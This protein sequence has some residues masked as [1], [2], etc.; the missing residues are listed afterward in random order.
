MKI[1]SVVFQ[2]LNSLVGTSTIH[3]PDNGVFAIVGPTG[4][5]KTTILDAICLALYGRTPRLNN[6]INSD[7]KE[8]EIISR[9][10][11]NCFAEVEFET[12]HNE[13]YIARWEHNRTNKSAKPTHRLYAYSNTNEKKILHGKTTDV[14]NNIQQITGLDFIQFTRSVLLAQGDFA[15]F[16][17]SDDKDRAEILEKITG[18]EIYKNISKKVYEKFKEKECNLKLLEEKLNEIKTLT[19]DEINSLNNNVAN[20]DNE[21]KLLSKKQ[22]SITDFLTFHKKLTEIQNESE[23]IKRNINSLNTAETEFHNDAAKLAAA[24]KANEINNQYNNYT[25]QKKLHDGIIKTIADVETDLPT[26]NNE[27]DNAKKNAE[28]SELLYNETKNNCEINQK[29]SIAAR[30]YDQKINELS[31]IIR[32]AENDK[33]ERTKKIAKLEKEQIEHE[34]NLAEILQEK[35]PELL[36]QK[37][38]NI[39]NTLAE[40]LNGKNISE[41]TDEREQLQ[42]KVKKLQFLYDSIVRI[43]SIN[44]DQNKIE[45][46]IQISNNSISQLEN[47]CIEIDEQKNLIEKYINELREKKQLLAVIAS[48]DEHRAKLENGKPC[49]LCGA[50]QHPYANGADPK[51]TNEE[52]EIKNTEEKIKNVN[53][54][55]KQ[56]NEKLAEK[57]RER[58]TWEIKRNNNIELI[59]QIIDKSNAAGVDKLPEKN[60]VQTEINQICLAADKIKKQIDETEKLN[61]EQKELNEKLQKSHKTNLEIQKIKAQIQEIKFENINTE[62]EINETGSKLN[63][64][65]EERIKIFGNENPDESDKK[66]EQLLINATK[67]R[68]ENNKI[69]AA[70]KSKVDNLTKRLEMLLDEKTKRGAEV[71]NTKRIFDECCIGSG[72]GTE[73]EFLSAIIEAE[74]LNELRAKESKFKEDRIRLNLLRDENIRKYKELT[75]SEI[76]RTDNFC[77]EK[78]IELLQKEKI[79]LD[80]KVKELS[81]QVGGLKEKLNANNEKNDEYKIKQNKFEQSRKEYDLWFKLNNLIGSQNGAKYSK[82]VQK[83]TF[84]SLITYANQQL[85]K[86]TDRYCLIHAAAKNDDRA[87]V[88]ELM[89]D[90]IDNYQGGTIRT[91]K[92]LSGGEV[93]LVSLSLALG[94]ASMASERIRVDSLFLDEGFGTLDEQTLDTVLGVLD[95]L[96]QG[97]KQIGV[98][99]HVPM[100]RQRITS[101]IR[102]LPNGNGRSKI[103]IALDRQ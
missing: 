9:N 63:L 35:T 47:Q 43:E 12:N 62:N 88:K 78:N 14:R 56:T 26:A 39:S 67:K 61:R 6:V 8:N 98:I 72:F 33:K 69:A 60:N 75:E 57:K 18:T 68:D 23:T 2:N 89:L 41:L 81:E 24:L 34:K 80:A 77:N 103:E 11:K 45:T 94:L 74:K 28:E 25:T 53:Q 48:L 32:K 49:P 16:L 96:R 99:S 85:S 40:I 84:Q 51:N 42:D 1:R 20:L 46:Q 76:T 90:I 29:N 91:I 37:I 97:G 101:Q 5:G 17:N 70:K 92:N 13:K 64:Q 79:E 73:T 22:N 87:A 52:T 54:K 102:V 66:S 86:I 27:F 10:T 82:I 95:G 7:T 83:M 93:F 3:F 15:K 44:A 30:Y 36:Q 59:S 4:V 38:N 55:L 50:C 71:D 100:I 19:Q 21:I 65:K 58:D 31:S